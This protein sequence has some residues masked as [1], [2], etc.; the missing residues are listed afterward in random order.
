MSTSAPP[1]HRTSKGSAPKLVKRE[2]DTLVTCMV[3]ALKHSETLCAITMRYM[4]REMSFTS[5]K[6]F[7][8]TNALYMLEIPRNLDGSPT[9]DHQEDAEM[10]SYGSS[11]SATKNEMAVTP[12]DTNNSSE[13]VI[14][15]VQHTE[16]ENNDAQP[17]RRSERSSVFPKRYNDF[18]VDSKEACKDQHWV[19]AMNKEMDA[20]Y[21]NDTWDISDLPIG[22]KW[23]YKIKYKSSGEI[24]RYKARYVV[25]GYNQKE[26]ID[27][28][29][30]FSPVVKIFT[31]RCLI[32]LAV[33][34]NW[35]L[36]QLDIN[37]AF[38]Y[39][40]LS[41]TVYMDLPEGYFSPDD[42]RVCRL[43]KSLYGLKQAPR[44]WN[45]KLTHTLIDNGFKQ[46]K[47]DYSL[48]TKSKNG[49]F[50][51]LLVY[52]DDIIIT[53]NNSTEIENFKKFLKTKFE[54]KDLGKLKYFLGI[55][56]L[57]TEQGLCLSQ[58]KY[59]LDLLS[60]FGLLACKPSATPLEQ[61]LSITNEPTDIDKVLDNIT[62]YQKLIG[63]LIYLTHT[64]PDISYFVHC[65]SQFMHKP[66]R[67]HL[68]IA[69]RVLRYLKGNPGK[70]VHIVRQPKAS[71][72]AFVDADWA[73]AMASVTSEVIWILKI[74]KDL[75]WDRVLH[76][77]LFCD[78]QAAIKIAANPVFHE[79]TK[80]LEIDL[81]FIRDEILAGVIKT[82]KIGT[83]VQPAD[84]FTKGLD[85]LQHKILVSK[86]GLI[87]VF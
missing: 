48:F 45:A 1:T 79:R 83:A 5:G 74:L 82:Q 66:L 25:K 18:V 22:G 17:V 76:V 63:K 20:L 86:L 43:K 49:N 38:L 15:D 44:Q 29:E 7:K 84:I 16:V 41:E 51:A 33:Q 81:H 80:H 39:G 68:R 32:N 70:G 40:D 53:G 10:P 46:S 57:E 31:V 85:K 9:F 24:E 14:G 65:L 8:L 2:T 73:K 23:V 60:D 87:D 13:G 11:G 67:S 59:S 4:E 47:S 27:F 56:V 26:G 28:D 37:N 12:E 42:K 52:V 6:E 58:R 55:E 34:Y 21:K 36:S 50:T 35:C 77:N 78:S 30:A 62:E 64:R 69:L 71:L 75:E 72:E 19:E 54:I 3:D 61:N